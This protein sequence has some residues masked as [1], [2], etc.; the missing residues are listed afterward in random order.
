VRPPSQLNIYFAFLM[1]ST[2]SAL[3]LQIIY[4]ECS[5]LQKA[6]EAAQAEFD[7]AAISLDDLAAASDFGEV[8]RH[9][10]AFLVSAGRIY[11]KLEQGA[12][13]SG[14]SQAWM[15]QRIHQRRTDALLS[16]LWHARNADEHT[17]EGVTDRHTGGTKFVDPSQ[18]EMAEF[19]RTMAAQGRPY[20]SLG[21]VEVV[22]PHVKLLDVTDRGVRYPIPQTHLGQAIS[23]PHPNNI[24][25]LALAYLEAMIAEARTM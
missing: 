17:V 21:L 10:A 22:F 20:V 12:K 18:E 4:L 15:G 13:T 1:L 2:D 9:W 16:Y 7:R 8:E 25:L 11:S 6:V 3:C 14:I 19:E 24:G 5:M 23:N